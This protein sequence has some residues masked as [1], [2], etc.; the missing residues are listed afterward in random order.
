MC[1]VSSLYAENVAGRDSRLVSCSRRAAQS[2]RHPRLKRCCG[3]HSRSQPLV[4]DSRDRVHSQD[5]VSVLSP[6][7]QDIPVLLCGFVHL[8]SMLSLPRRIDLD[9]GVI[10]GTDDSML[11]L[12]RYSAFSIT[13]IPR[14]YAHKNIPAAIWFSLLQVSAVRFRFLINLPSSSSSK[15]LGMDVPGAAVFEA[16][17]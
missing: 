15:A 8:L 5:S 13:C 2:R 16:P 12:T 1:V 10:V 3:E 4:T 14:R 11:F 9:T 7:W 17:S 6:I